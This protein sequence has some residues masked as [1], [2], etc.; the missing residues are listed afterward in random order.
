MK[1]TGK[2]WDTCRVEKM[3]CIGCYYDEIEVEE[4]IRTDKGYIFKVDTEKK[5]L[6]AIK[7]LDIQY[8]NIIDHKKKLIDLVKEDDYVNGH[9]IVK[10]RIDPFNNKKQL[11]TEHWEYN[12][13]GDGTL[14]IFY[15][16]DI[17]ILTT[18]EQFLSVGF[19]RKGV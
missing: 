9:R 18:K 17:K 8:G 19:E 1:C 15:D 12:W 7:F 6:G 16:E 13:Q 5:I 10:I 2:E 4:Y 3:G 14:L 11:F